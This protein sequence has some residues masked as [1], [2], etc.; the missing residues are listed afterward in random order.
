M[1]SICMYMHHFFSY[2]KLRLTLHV[3]QFANLALSYSKL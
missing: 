2:S 1:T 3:V